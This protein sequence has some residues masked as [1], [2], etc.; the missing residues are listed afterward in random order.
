[1]KN[2]Q[3]PNFYS[4]IIRLRYSH[5]LLKFEF[6]FVSLLVVFAGIYP[7]LAGA[8]FFPQALSFLPLGGT[9]YHILILTLGFIGFFLA[10]KARR[11]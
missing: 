9:W 11:P 2:G 7:L 10:L 4:G 8:S 1:M 5:T 3:T 6:L